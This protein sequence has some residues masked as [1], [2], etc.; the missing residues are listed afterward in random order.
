[1]DG[2]D[3]PTRRRIG[4]RIVR[5]P[6]GQH[7]GFEL[8]RLEVDACSVRLPRRPEVANGVGVAHG[9]AISAL[10]D[11]AAVGAAWASPGLGESS[12]GA[13]AGLTVSYLAPSRESDLL[14]EARVLRRG[15][16]IV[17]VEVDVSDAAGNHVARGLV[18]YR[19]QR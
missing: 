2:I 5:G 18:T 16:A 9:G 13:T 17:V 6:F 1:M 3:E 7:L 11:T 15:R 19:L 8:E 14:A 12:R 4:E 10:V